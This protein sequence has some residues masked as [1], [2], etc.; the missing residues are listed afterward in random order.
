MTPEEF[1]ANFETVAEAPE[2]I[3]RLRELILNLAVRGCLVEQR[4]VEG[5][6]QNVISA[7]NDE[8][9]RLLS[10]G[11]LRATRAM[12]DSDDYGKDD[13]AP[14]MLPASWVWTKLS[15]LSACETNAIT[16][17]PFGT[18]LMTAHYI[19]EPGF[20]VVRLGN[21][22][23]G[24]YIWDKDA[25]IDESR[26]Q[27]L[28]KH[29]VFA[30]DLLIA[31]LA[32]PVGRACLVP[33]SLGPALVKADCYR[34]KSH[35]SIDS[36]FLMHVLNAPTSRAQAEGMNHGITRTRINLSN[37]RSIIVPLP[38]LKEQKRI[39]AKVDHLMALCD[40]LEARQAKKR[41][42]AVRLNRAALD[43]LTTAEGPEEV[44][45]SFRRITENFEVLV[46][47]PESVKGLRKAIL[48]LAIHGQL[49][50]HIPSHVES[51]ITPTSHGNKSTVA[52]EIPRGWR[53]ER[54]ANIID[55]AYPISYGVLVPGPE[56]DKGVPFVRIQD[57]N[58]QNPTVAP[59]KRI[60][61][62]IEAKY[63]RTRLVGGEL[64]LG[65]V[66]S[67]GKLGIVPDT[68]KGANIARAV[69]R[70]MPHRLTVEVDYLRVFLQSNFAQ[71]YFVEATRTLAQPTLNVGA[72]RETPVPLPPLAEQK[73]IVAKVDQLMALCD[74]L[75]NAL[76]RA[77]STA[78]K[79]AEAV[80]AEIVA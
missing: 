78:Q 65:V 42:T 47:K 6:A 68:W 44:A 7:I 13:S 4:H 14:Y 63:A 24:K 67:I 60:S 66:G 10:A 70:I 57:L 20:R 8:R 9:S 50:R 22:G 55:P 21:I 30:G 62:D 61:A 37:L 49:V 59:V 46:D 56:V 31:G 45:A 16:D 41:E 3:K 53:W 5:S 28:A 19:A 40:D 38:P 71:K 80:V 23:V 77:E 51:H 58:T 29:H 69:C 79:L 54:L 73:R 25:Y 17:G 36:R 43:A 72:I 18:N 48:D 74:T 34:M 15:E 11:K 76:R 1:V 2:G 39:V 12:R 32:D 35:L 27:R 64:L 52:F 75:E 33:D 26:F